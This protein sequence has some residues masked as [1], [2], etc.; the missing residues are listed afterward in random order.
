MTEEAFNVYRDVFNSCL[1][2]N[3]FVVVPTWILILHIYLII[4]IYLLF[5]FPVSF[6]WVSLFCTFKPPSSLMRCWGLSLQLQCF[7]LEDLLD[8]D[9]WLDSCLRCSLCLCVAFLRSHEDERERDF[10]LQ[11]DLNRQHAVNAIIS[12]NHQPQVKHFLNVL[13]SLYLWLFLNVQ[14]E[15]IN[16]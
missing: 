4:I 1:P 16:R 3:I 7:L 15:S 6:R 12:N 14:W 13:K 11:R 10:L 2:F 9:E 5:F 8:A